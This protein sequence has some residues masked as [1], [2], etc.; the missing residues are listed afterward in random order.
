MDTNRLKLES[1]LKTM[2]VNKQQIENILNIYDCF[3][4]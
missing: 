3:W 4:R 2:P 1:I